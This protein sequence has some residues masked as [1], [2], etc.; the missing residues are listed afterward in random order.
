MPVK[1]MAV[2]VQPEN[3]DLFK[4]SLH[5]VIMK[6]CA[7]LLTLLSLAT[8][9]SVFAADADRIFVGDFEPPPDNDTCE[10]A[11]P[12]TLGSQVLGTTHDATPNYSS[13]LETCTGFE[14]PGQ[15]VVYSISMVA[16]SSYS[17]YLAPEASFDASVS[18]LGPGTASVC[19]ITPVHCLVGSDNGFSGD[20][21]SFLF[22]ATQTGTYYIIVDSFLTGETGSGSFSIQVTSP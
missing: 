19:N 14:Q 20:P 12:L 1:V 8:S 9:L 15:D 18:L 4:A 13:G 7:Q 22:T 10:T 2:E 16:G 17:V 5:R 21:E 6:R 11:K 3:S